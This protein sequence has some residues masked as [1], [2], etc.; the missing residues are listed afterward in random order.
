MKELLDRIT[1]KRL[2]EII[3]RE[4]PFDITPEEIDLLATIA[5]KAKR[6]EEE[7]QEKQQIDQERLSEL[8]EG[9]EVSVDVSTCDADI[10]NRYFGTVTEVSELETGKHGVILLVQDAEPNFK[11]QS[12]PV[13]YTSVDALADVSCELTGMMGPKNV[14]GNVPLYTTFQPGGGE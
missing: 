14:V 5:L 11:L 13:A 3:L 12:D 2:H 9:M 7:P 8:L 1:V 6:S 10:G 4:T